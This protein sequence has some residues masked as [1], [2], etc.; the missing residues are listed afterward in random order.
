MSAARPV[1]KCILTDTFRD[2]QIFEIEFDYEEVI[3]ESIEKFDEH[4][5]VYIAS[6]IEKKLI[7][8]M[9]RCHRKECSQCIAVFDENEKA[10]DDFIKL[11]SETTQIRKPCISTV[12]ILKATNKIIELLF[13]CPTECNDYMYE[14]VIKTTMQHLD[15]E[16]LYTQS[17]FTVHPG[18]SSDILSHKQVFMY[19]IVDEYMKMKSR[20]IGARISEEKRGKYIRHNNKKRTH[21]AGQ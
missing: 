10:D 5:C 1:E 12:H 9:T 2:G 3:H 7:Q 17:D 13:N 18:K 6:L 21:E 16:K 15:E 20:K 4:S 8:T 11:R 19:K 14:S